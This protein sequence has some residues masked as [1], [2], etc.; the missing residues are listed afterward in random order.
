MTQ[1]EI[2]AHV[3][4]LMVELFELSPAQVTPEA[5]LVNDLDLDSLDAVDMAV[6]LEELTGHRVDEAALRSVRTVG[7][8]VA[9]VDTILNPRAPE[10]S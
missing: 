10:P 4:K 8:V 5:H 7:D 9:L 6:K 2:L 3:Q 1:P